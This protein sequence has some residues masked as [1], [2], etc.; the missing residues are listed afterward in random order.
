MFR[1][2][3]HGAVSITSDADDTSRSTV[4]GIKYSVRSLVFDGIGIGI[5]SCKLQH[6]LL[7]QTPLANSMMKNLLDVVVYMT[8]CM[9]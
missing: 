8:S 7:M 2:A 9:I 6:F 1:E 5:P 4:Y 3:K